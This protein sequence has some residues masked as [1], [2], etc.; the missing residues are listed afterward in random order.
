MAQYRLFGPSFHI[1]QIRSVNSDTLRA[2]IGLRVMNAEGGLHNDW[3]PQ[4]VFLGDHHPGDTVDVNA[5]GIGYPD[6]DVPDPTPAN[7]DGGA[8]YW[9]FLFSLTQARET[10]RTSPGFL[11]KPLSIISA[12]LEATSKLYFIIAGG[13][14]AGLGDLVQALAAGH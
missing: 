3:P 12:A 7:P 10:L 13:L 11:T 8:M 5:L 1:N 4:S 2:G 9:T 6:V 14:I